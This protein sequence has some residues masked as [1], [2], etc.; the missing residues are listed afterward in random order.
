MPI[1][2][3]EVVLILVAIVGNAIKVLGQVSVVDDLFR[4]RQEA[5]VASFCV[6]SEDLGQDWH[7]RNNSDG[8]ESREHQP[9]KLVRGQ[10]GA[11]V[12]CASS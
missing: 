1:P 11:S 12:P 3:R 5:I 6:L 9:A 7:A 4:R 2:H 10:F 8:I